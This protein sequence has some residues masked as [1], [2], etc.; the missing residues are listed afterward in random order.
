MFYV[1][2]LIFFIIVLIKHKYKNKMTKEGQP[3]VHLGEMNLSA[4]A[5]APNDKY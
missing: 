4:Y 2:I 5:K 1:Y 3:T